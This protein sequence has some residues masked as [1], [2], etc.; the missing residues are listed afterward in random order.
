[1]IFRTSNIA[2]INRPVTF[3]LYELECYFF[4]IGVDI[5]CSFYFKRVFGKYDPASPKNP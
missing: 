1:M 2:K 3:L 5:G 4:L